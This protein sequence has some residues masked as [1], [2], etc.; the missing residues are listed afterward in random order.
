MRINV[1]IPSSHKPSAT[2]PLAR[3]R[4]DAVACRPGVSSVPG[5]KLRIVNRLQTQEGFPQR[6]TNGRYSGL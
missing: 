1:Y 5:M 3:F 2:V 4:R 6:G